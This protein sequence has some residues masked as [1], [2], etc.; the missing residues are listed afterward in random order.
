MNKKITF[1]LLGILL[2]ASMSAQ[3]KTCHLNI[4]GGNYK[5]APVPDYTRWYYFS[6]A[7]G[8]TIGSSAAV[9]T[10][11]GSSRAGAEV[12]DEAWKARTDWDIA[13]HACDI[14]TNG[15]DAGSGQAGALLVADT[16]S[17]APLADVFAALHEAPAAQYAPDELLTGTFIFGMEFMP[18][19]RAT[20]LLASAAAHGWATVGMEGSAESPRI[21]VFKTAGG[22]YVKVHLK[23]FVDADGNPG[24]IEFDYA[25]IPP[26]E[27]MGIETPPAAAATVYSADG[28][29][30]VDAAGRTDVYVYTVSGALAAHVRVQAGRTPIPVQAPTEGVYIVKT[31]SDG[32]VST[33][34]VV[35]K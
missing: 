15:G 19:L 17:A 29:L 18:P 7:Q 20:Q 13:F 26:A 9:L 12:I 31:V 8:D 16:S 11:V 5:G 25:S 21:I 22:E 23:K 2:V 27:G 14:R 10:D 6:F 35:L 30:Y 28:A 3:V 1:S 4:S 33:Q 34:K 32:A 24:F